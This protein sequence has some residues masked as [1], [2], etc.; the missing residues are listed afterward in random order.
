VA[1]AAA[2]A[3][4]AGVAGAA[5]GRAGGRGESGAVFLLVRGGAPP[6]VTRTAPESGAAARVTCPAGDLLA[7]LA[8]DD[9]PDLVVEGDGRPLERV[10]A[11]LNAAQS[12][13]KRMV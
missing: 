6:L 7:V 4:A 9:V 13:E 11:W 1:G 10:R 12:G 5:G 8:G 3:G 2:G